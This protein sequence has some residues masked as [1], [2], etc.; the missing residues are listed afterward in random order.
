M[1]FESALFRPTTGSYDRAAVTAHLDALPHAFRDPIAG[2]KFHLS[3]TSASARANREARVRDPSRFPY[4]V[5]VELRP[6][7][8]LVDQAPIGDALARARALVSWLLEQGSFTVETELGKPR[9]VD[10]NELYPDPLPDLDTLLDDLFSSPPLLGVLWT[11]REGD[12]V[13]QLSQGRHWRLERPGLPP[14]LG[15][16]SPADA[17]A[18]QKLSAALD[19]DAID[20]GASDDP[21]EI[22]S[23]TRESPDEE[24]VLYYDRRHPPAEVADALSALAHWRSEAR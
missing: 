11:W 21:A 12:I 8:V 3:G 22:A 15:Q 14:Q 5:L 17:A 23:L 20:A 18:W 10:I 1:A 6:E 19:P 13:W 4:G 9:P 7:G 16:L 24:A 2:V